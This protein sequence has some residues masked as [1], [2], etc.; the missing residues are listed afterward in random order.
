MV[1]PRQEALDHE[2]KG[3]PDGAP[4]ERDSLWRHTFAPNVGAP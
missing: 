1:H 2:A 3:R 4:G